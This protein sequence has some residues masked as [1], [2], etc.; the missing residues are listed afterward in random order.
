MHTYEVHSPY[1]PPPDFDLFAPDPDQLQ[2]RARAAYKGGILYADNELS[3]L[4]SALERFGLSERTVLIVT[5]DHGEAF[6]EHGV[7]GHGRHLIEELLHVPLLV[8]APDLAPRGGRVGQAVS[9]V[10]IAPTI[11]DLA[12][13]P[14]PPTMQGRSLVAVL[15]GDQGVAP[16]PVYS[17]GEVGVDGKE[18][19]RTIAAREG[20]LKWLLPGD[21]AP[22]RAFDL[23]RGEGSG[24]E[25][26]SPEV[27][28]RGRVLRRRF[29]ESV[30]KSKAAMKSSPV[31]DVEIDEEL[32][33]QLRALG[34]VE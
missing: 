18:I 29:D 12:D 24:M 22:V 14:T 17:E 25:L 19:G 4:V 30:R 11:L 20:D 16:V 13:L 23:T 34:Y 26:A 15:S 27:L 33:G 8:R 10:D 21:G 2:P 6:G 3:R 31:P 9:L 32:Q 5:S 7:V 28:A 1:R